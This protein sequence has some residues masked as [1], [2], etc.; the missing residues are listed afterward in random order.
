MEPEREC[1]S[2]FSIH[3]KI[4]N[5]IR[6]INVSESTRVREVKEM[7]CHFI[8]PGFHDIEK[9]YLWKGEVQMSDLAI[10]RDCEVSANDH[11]ELKRKRSRG[12]KSSASR[13]LHSFV[14]KQSD[15][16]EHRLQLL[17]YYRALW[18]KA[19]PAEFENV[20]NVPPEDQVLPLTA[21]HHEILEQ[22]SCA[23]EQLVDL[24]EELQEEGPVASSL[25]ATQPTLAAPPALAASASES[26]SV[27]AAA[28]GSGQP[29]L[30]ENH[31]HTH[32]VRHDDAG[33][34]TNTLIP[35]MTANELEKTYGKGFKLMKL[36]GYTEGQGLGVPSRQGIVGI[37]PSGDMLQNPSR[38][39]GAGS[40]TD[41]AELIRCVDSASINPPECSSCNKHQWP[42]YKTRNKGKWI[43][44]ECAQISGPKCVKC[45]TETWNGYNI[46]WNTNEF[47]SN[48]WGK[49]LCASCWISSSESDHFHWGEW[50]KRRAESYPEVL[51]ECSA[52]EAKKVEFQSYEWTPG[53][54]TSL[55]TLLRRQPSD[56]T[57]K[58][59]DEY[60]LGRKG[61]WHLQNDGQ[62]PPP[63]D[64]APEP[65]P[66]FFHKFLSSRKNQKGKPLSEMFGPPEPKDE[67][68]MYHARKFDSV[69]KE[70]IGDKARN[71]QHGYHASRFPCIHNTLC[72]GLKNAVTMKT[73]KG[74]YVPG[75][76]HF[77]H[78][79]R[80]LY[81]HRYQ[82]FADGTAWCIVWHILADPSK[83]QSALDEQWATLQEGVEII[84]AY[85]RG[86]TYEA[87]KAFM[88]KPPH[89]RPDM[90]L[91]SQ[92]QPEL[93][94]PVD[95]GRKNRQK[96]KGLLCSA[97]FGKLSRFFLDI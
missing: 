88:E 19:P 46:P 30:V 72:N 5:D 29:T 96:L 23:I 41:T 92:W 20:P 36:L 68:W 26:D 65:D 3:I 13:G 37:V 84:G 64:C 85:T 93:E 67:G 77:Q 4:G 33:V 22:A 34:T 78:L 11:L 27:S 74:K 45:T 38:G 24:D 62:F 79:P 59:A 47:P 66:D 1:T 14:Y 10:L 75:V 57:P 16:R 17:Q 51:M 55:A 91:V 81:Y 76:Y 12:G 28:G 82:L 6:E 49:W 35:Q 48:L 39:I 69:K 43:C 40:S 73:K 42:A 50:F 25:L 53:R 61:W 87:W 54:A 7:C 97:S 2:S 32:S 15:S 94:H 95:V 80:G 21:S 89:E 52:C 60:V 83:T 31:D 8:G 44:K 58:W 86:Y 70:L 18:D 71:W 56:T 90:T 63:D 9:I